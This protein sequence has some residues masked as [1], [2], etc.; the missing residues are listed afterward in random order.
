MGVPPLGNGEAPDP[1]TDDELSALALAAH[2]DPSVEDDAQCVWDVV[3]HGSI[4]LLPEWYMP[5][6]GVGPRHFTGRQR[7]LVLLTV[8]LTISSFLT[9]TAAGL[10]NTYGQ[11]HWR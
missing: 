1:F 2:P 5:S 8:I 10:C 7:R 9:I 6:P 3:G 11:L 4:H